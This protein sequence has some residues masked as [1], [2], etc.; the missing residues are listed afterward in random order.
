MVINSH[1]PIQKLMVRLN[2]LPTAPVV[3]KLRFSILKTT[4]ALSTYRK[5]G[6][7]ILVLGK[8]GFNQIK[9]ADQIYF[10]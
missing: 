9:L 4:G 3:M 8:A 10:A 7:C 6:R 2:A 5:C 1:L